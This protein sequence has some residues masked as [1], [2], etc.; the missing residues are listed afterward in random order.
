MFEILKKGLIFWL[1]GVCNLIVG[2]L[3]SS[4]SCS[5][6][7]SWAFCNCRKRE[8]C[9]I[10]SRS[11]LTC[12]KAEKTKWS[13]NK[14]LAKCTFHQGVPICWRPHFLFS[15]RNTVRKRGTDLGPKEH[16]KKKRWRWSVD[17]DFLA[18]QSTR[19]K[20]IWNLNLEVKSNRNPLGVCT[21]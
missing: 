16:E 10:S 19:S 9:I 13:N 1:D 14:L 15:K 12:A 2:Q 3:A 6:S 11:V 5:L 17:D 8:G 20:L 4:V 7:Y 21:R 18:L